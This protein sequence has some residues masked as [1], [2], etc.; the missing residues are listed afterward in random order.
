VERV[1]PQVS[2]CPP[3]QNSG[4]SNSQVY[5]PPKD[6][7][8]KFLFK[9]HD[10]IEPRRTA[11]SIAGSAAEVEDARAERKS[12]AHQ[13]RVQQMSGVKGYSLLF[14]PSPAMRTAYPHLKRLWTMGPTAA[15]YDT[16]Y[17]VLLNV[18]PHH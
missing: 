9:V 3:G 1:G 2:L 6:L 8:G 14:A 11:T 4:I 18:L 13:T 5:F 10:R 7:S 16:M 12:V 15:P 17:L